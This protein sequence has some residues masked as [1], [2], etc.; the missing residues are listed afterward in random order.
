MVSE[1][2]YTI[3]KEKVLKAFNIFVN[4]FLIE[5]K[6][7]LTDE[8]RDELTDELT[9]ELNNFNDD[10]LNDI[11]TRYIQGGIE[12]SDKNF[13]E[14]L[15]VQFGDAS[16]RKRLL[17]AHFEWLWL[18]TASSS[19]RESKKGYTEY[20]LTKLGRNDTDDSE[21]KVI[22]YKDDIYIEG[23]AGFGRSYNSKYHDIKY[24]IILTELIWKNLEILDFED[25]EQ[26]FIIKCLIHDICMHIIYTDEDNYSKQKLKDKYGI[27]F[28]DF[29]EYFEKDKDFNHHLPISH[30]LLFLCKPN[31][32]QAIIKEADKE[33]I[34]NSFQDMLGDENRDENR[35]KLIETIFSNLGEIPKLAEIETFYESILIPFW[36]LDSDKSIFNEVEALKYKKA[37]VLYGPPGTS[38]TFSAKMIAESVCKNYDYNVSNL[39]IEEI[40]EKDYY[41]ENTKQIFRLQLH[42]NYTYQDFIGGIQLRNDNTEAVA[43][44]LYDVTDKCDEEK[45][46]P[47]F[48]ILDEINRTDLSS[49]FGEVFSAIENRGEEVDVSVPFEK[50]DP[51]N[52]LTIPDNLYVIGTMNEIDFSLERLDFA[53]RRRFLWFEY[54]FDDERLLD[55]INYKLDK[56]KS[57]ILKSK[58]QGSDEVTTYIERCKDLNKAIQE[59]ELLGDQY[60][61]GHTFFAEVIDIC[62]KF[63]ISIR[64]Q[65][66]LIKG[67]GPAKVLWDISIEP[68]LDAFLGA[69]DPKTK[70]ET[71]DQFRDIFKPETS[72]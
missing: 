22:N 36:K 67:D 3:R 38:K 29:W 62:E 10:D 28:D 50:D 6:N 34:I 44:K 14:K 43:G 23:V 66:F 31:N 71:I 45:D 60:Q 18:F 68:I 5:K 48:L 17:F 9:N 12:G 51:R 1:K 64:T 25:N 63:N 19:S 54:N 57:K 21:P 65:Q 61:I 7:I 24:C 49:M 39:T 59:N 35:E 27:D 30:M 56:T 13:D 46:K 15:K 70:K 8:L 72:K 53:M 11:K 37:I 41:D 69:T 55:I 2:S 40:L 26:D 20:A 58:L 52:K 47:V 16:Y 32:H 42:E 33:A 4:D